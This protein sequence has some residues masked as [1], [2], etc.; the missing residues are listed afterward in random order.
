MA[1]LLGILFVFSVMIGSAVI[2]VVLFRSQRRSRRLQTPEPVKFRRA[3]GETLR[4]RM[5]ELSDRFATTILVGS[6]VAICL[7]GVPG[8]VV[9]WVPNAY[10]I[11]LF[12][13]GMALFA[14]GAIVMLRRS[15]RILDERA[16]ARLG[17]IGEGLVAE[18]LESCL[19]RGCRVFHDVPIHGEWGQANLDHVVVGPNGVAVVE[20]KMRAKPSDKQAWEN[21]VTFDGKVLAWPRCP[22]DSKTLWQVRKNAE[23][24]EAYLLKECDVSSPV[25]RVI[26]IPGWNVVEKAL[27][28]PRV[29]SGKGAGDA[30]LQAL[31]A[32]GN[33][34]LSP[35]EIDLVSVALETLCRDVEI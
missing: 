19:A 28:Q 31:D 4:R 23:W 34:R 20:T 14:A 11:F 27:G 22:D 29:V 18:S 1:T 10:P 3:P 16:R 32:N 21:R 30:V 17:F 5:E 6:S 9:R 7:L 12:G 26:A 2:A 25:K 35:A 13:S 33:H 8:L 15:V 24:L